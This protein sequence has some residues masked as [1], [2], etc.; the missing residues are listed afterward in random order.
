MKFH[1]AAYKSSGIKTQKVYKN[2]SSKILIKKREGEICKYIK[3]LEKINIYTCL[4]LIIRAAN[5]LISFE[6]YMIGHQYWL[7][8]FFE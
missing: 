1:F 2:S 6:N 8:Q 5:Y 3:R 7:K 4:Q